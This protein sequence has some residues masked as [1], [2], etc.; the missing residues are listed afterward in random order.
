MGY[1]FGG[2]G[3]QPDGH[4]KRMDDLA[5]RALAEKPSVT[6][7]ASVSAAVATPPRD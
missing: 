2:P 4:D 1:M 6:A 5:E 7:T 3:W